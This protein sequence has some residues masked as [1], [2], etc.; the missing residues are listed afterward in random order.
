MSNLAQSIWRKINRKCIAYQATFLAPNQ[1]MGG[2]PAEVLADL[3]KFCGAFKPATRKDNLNRIDPIATAQQIGRLEVWQR[4]QGFI[5]IPE[6]DV[7]RMS[8][9]LTDDE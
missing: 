7:A 4:I 9:A 3:S 5:N 2:A 1:T 8:M 6:R